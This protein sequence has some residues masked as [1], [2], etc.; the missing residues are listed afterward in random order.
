[1]GCALKTKF[2]NP[3]FFFPSLLAIENFQNHFSLKTSI[4]IALFGKTLSTRKGCFATSPG[5]TNYHMM[6]GCATLLGLMLCMVLLLG[7]FHT[8][9]SPPR[10]LPM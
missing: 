2:T 10:N 9:E 3:I 6:E 1:V 8:T 4:L 5:R 7:P